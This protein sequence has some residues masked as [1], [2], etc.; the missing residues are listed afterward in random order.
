VSMSRIPFDQLPAEVRQ[1]IADKTGA[2]HQAVTTPGG[3]NSGIASVLDTD[4]GPVFVKGIPTDHPQVSAQHR[5]ATVAPHLPSSCPRLFW[6]LE[7][8]G[9]SLLGHEV[10]NGRHADYAPGSPDLPLAEAAHAELQG[11]H[12][13]SRRRH[14][15]GRGPVGRIRATWHVAALRR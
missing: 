13:T 12:R 11:D 6:H 5:E 1:A 2:V 15:A 4:S 9:W 14:Q 7:L 10:V 8:G 3:M